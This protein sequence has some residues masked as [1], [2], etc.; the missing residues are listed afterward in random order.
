MTLDSKVPPAPTV[1][2]SRGRTLAIRM[3]I[4]LG[5]GTL[6]VVIFVQLIDF[7]SAWRRVEHLNVA[8][9]LLCGVVFLSAYAV[10]A[11]RWRLF[12]A[13]DKITVPRVIGIY[14]VAT[15]LNWALPI[16][17]GELAKSLILRRT[18]GIPVSRSLATV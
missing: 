2:A 16:Q 15:F 7:H 14:F 3:A 10:R 18:N 8:I 9:A 4:G 17:G 12:L 11:L 5:I 13:P 1:G 6:F